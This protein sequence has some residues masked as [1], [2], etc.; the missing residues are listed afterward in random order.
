[1][2]VEFVAKSDLVII[3]APAAIETAYAN[4][5]MLEGVGGDN[6]LLFPFLASAMFFLLPVTTTVQPGFCTV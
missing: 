6:N 4:V 2:Y 5:F 3:P 1:L